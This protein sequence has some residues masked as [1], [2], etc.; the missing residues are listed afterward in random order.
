M[1]RTEL[2]VIGAGPAGLAAATTAAAHGV[3]VTLIDELPAPGGQYLAPAGAPG[4]AHAPLS[5]AERRGHALLDALPGS[6]ID[7]RSETIVWNMAADRRLGAAR[8]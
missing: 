6:G 8:R 7:V 5:A 1:T 3:Q 4:R 2:A